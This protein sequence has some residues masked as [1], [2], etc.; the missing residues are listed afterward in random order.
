[1]DYFQWPKP[2]LLSS[3]IEE[4]V[5]WQGKSLIQREKRVVFYQGKHWLV[6]FRRD[7]ESLKREHLAYLLGR[8]W[9]N[10]AEVL[11]LNEEEF[12]SIVSLGVP[13]TNNASIH[14]TYLVRL[15]QDHSFEELPNTDIDTTTAGE[16]VFS[17][18]IRRRDT[19]AANR[20][21]NNGI[22]IFFDHQTAFLGEPHLRNHYAFFLSRA[23]FGHPGRWRLRK[24]GDKEKISTMNARRA[25]LSENLALHFV[26][27]HEQFDKSIATFVNCLKE[28]SSDHWNQAILKAGY[29]RDKAKRIADFLSENHQNLESSVELMRS[30]LLARNSV[31]SCWNL[32]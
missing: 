14:N 1:M 15:A 4:L 13:L 24:L 17:L 7:P 21:Y 3:W 32:H 29:D 18:W 27:N 25:C 30:V 11:P 28:Q 20:V 8:D 2:T 16:L 9:L 5:D 26:R 19:H 22:P 12:N 6:K 10:I 23:D 31:V